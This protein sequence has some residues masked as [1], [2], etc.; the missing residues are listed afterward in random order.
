MKGSKF[1]HHSS[2]SKTNVA[3]LINN[4]ILDQ[5]YL[6]PMLGD[7]KGEFKWLVVKGREVKLLKLLFDSLSSSLEDPATSEP[8][9]YIFKAIL[10]ATG[11]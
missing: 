9:H 5:K 8:P 2:A 11:I 4:N 1:F 3:C 7:H 6:N 10:K